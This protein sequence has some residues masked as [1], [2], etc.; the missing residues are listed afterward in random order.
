MTSS[1]LSPLKT[2]ALV[3]GAAVLLT[4]PLTSLAMAHGHHHHRHGVRI[5]IGG[6][7]GFYGHYGPTLRRQLPAF[8][9]AGPG[10]RKSVL[11]E[12]L[13]LLH[14]RLSEDGP[15]LALIIARRPVAAPVAATGRAI[16]L[17][18]SDSTP[19]LSS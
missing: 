6:G 18:V 8:E 10:N 5:F 19:V 16:C 14:V 9:A 2:S 15:Q 17:G 12:A 11:V 4:G 7:P 1:K 3:L 13:P